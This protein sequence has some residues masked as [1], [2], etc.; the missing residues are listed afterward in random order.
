MLSILQY[1]QARELWRYSYPCGLRCFSCWFF[2]VCY[3]MLCYAMLWLL[4]CCV[5]V[6][7]IVVVFRLSHRHLCPRAYDRQ[8]YLTLLVIASD[9]QTYLSLAS[10]PSPYCSVFGSLTWQF[11]KAWY[12]TDCFCLVLFLRGK[13]PDARGRYRAYSRVNAEDVPRTNRFGFS[14]IGPSESFKE[15]SWFCFRSWQK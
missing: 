14:H 3:A 8:T 11:E 2:L 6:F 5:A 7:V 10:S 1:V 15:K 9:G 12:N 13:R 4:C